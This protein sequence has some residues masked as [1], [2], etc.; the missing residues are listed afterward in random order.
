MGDKKSIRKT[1]T[2]YLQTFASRTSLFV[3]RQTAAGFS[4]LQCPATVVMVATLGLATCILEV[5]VLS[6]VELPW[7]T[8]HGNH[9]M[10]DDVFRGNSTGTKP[11][12]TPW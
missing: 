10:E 8:F 7:K 12:E 1:C 4:P 2:T 6:S 9:S 11:R 5:Q 3:F